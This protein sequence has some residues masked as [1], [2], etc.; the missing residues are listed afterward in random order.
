LSKNN[1]SI[2]GIYQYLENTNV[3]SYILKQSIEVDNDKWFLDSI[4]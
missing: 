2:Y 4:K 3:A 1:K